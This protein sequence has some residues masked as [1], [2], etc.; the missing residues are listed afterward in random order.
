M[1]LFATISGRTPHDIKDTA[2]DVCWRRWYSAGVCQQ[3]V[4]FDVFYMPNISY[5]RRRSL[6]WSGNS[7]NNNLP[8]EDSIMRVWVCW[9]HN[10]SDRRK[11]VFC[12][13]KSVQIITNNFQKHEMKY[14][15]IIRYLVI[16][17]NVKNN[18][19]FKDQ[20]D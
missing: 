1:N 2:G 19:I 4:H 18:V 9:R 3:S 10:R 8:F 6:C 16:I 14:L 7:E 13:G 11:N 15:K 17:P 5:K 20:H 12:I